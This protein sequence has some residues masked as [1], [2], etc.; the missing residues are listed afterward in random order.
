[1]RLKNGNLLCG[2]RFRSSQRSKE[3]ESLHNTSEKYRTTNSCHG[4]DRLL[5]KPLKSCI[6]A[7][8]TDVNVPVVYIHCESRIIS[9]E[10]S[11]EHVTVRSI[12]PAIMNTDL[13]SEFVEIPELLCDDY[14]ETISNH[15]KLNSDEKQDIK[16]EPIKCLHCESTFTSLVHLLDH[17]KVHIDPANL[18]V[19]SKFV[20]GDCGV[21]FS[22]VNKNEFI[23]HCRSHDRIKPFRCQICDYRFN[24]L[25]DIWRH[26]ARKHSEP[27]LPCFVCDKHFALLEKL[28]DH[29]RWHFDGILYKCSQCS[30]E[31]SSY[32]LYDIHRSKHIGMTKFKCNQCAKEFQDIV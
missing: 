19:Y 28:K 11:R 9:Q 12:D 27:K 8:I 32:S 24:S 5:E 14:G 30:A 21:T 6:D 15:D 31:F 17:I 29:V 3:L 22:K 25:Y 16:K 1:M 2:I 18:K 26:E 10:D 23:H 20:C 13:N 7:R 4:G